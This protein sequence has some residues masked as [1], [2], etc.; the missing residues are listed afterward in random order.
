MKTKKIFSVPIN[1]KLSELEFAEFYSFC[2]HH[3]D[4][5]SDLY[6]TSRI[7]P[8]TQDAMGD[9]FVIN[10]DRTGLIENALNIQKY[11]GIP[12]SATFNNTTISPTQQNL[13]TFIKNFKPLYDAGIKIATIP[14][15]HWMAT[16]QIK[17]AFPDLFVKN[18]ILR[19]VRTAVEIVNLAKYGF[20]Y[21]NLDRDLMR[22]RDTLLR[23]KEAKM[24]I[25]KNL[26][27]KIQYSLLAN[28]GCLGACPMMVEHFEFN[29]TRIERSPQY[30]N[31]PISR[32]SCPKW[33]VEDPSVFL[34]TASLPP[35]RSDWEEF[36]D[37]LGIDVFKM[38]G[39]ESVDRLKETMTLIS[40]Y[41]K[42][43]E[44]LYPTFVDWLK[45]T[46]LEEKP[47]DIWRE[48]IKNCK[49]DCWECQYCDKITEKKSSWDYSDLVKHTAQC[50]ADSGIPKLKNEIP[51]LTSSRVRTLINSL[52]KGV[53]SYL[54]VGS[55][56]GAT[57]TAALANNMLSA[58]FV[59]KWQENIQPQRE[60]IVTPDNSKKAFLKNIEKVSGNSLVKVYDN[61]LFETP[62]H[63]FTNQIQ[64]FF[65]DGP[66]DHDSTSQAVQYYWSCFQTECILVFDDANWEGVVSGANQ[67]IE[68][69]KG[70]M[71]YKKIILN[72]E[73]NPNEWWNGL[74]VVVI[75]KEHENY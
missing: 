43:E 30:F 45:E 5:I 7:A 56:L 72:S 73:E 66:H 71:V 61:D 74:Y 11:L 41:A 49:F 38:H 50:I 8:F 31:D 26:G 16:G 2:E 47:I 59:D 53:G 21:I 42:G 20:D 46:N 39:R 62:I 48:K 13:D 44:I 27:K 4:W 29:N 32:V 65:Y 69:M 24:W 51:G 23:L 18:T 34:K 6:F 3:K 60:D 37:N 15:T 64:M 36:L 57:A 10:E 35:W 22:D 1:P 67:G 19:D 12:I 40:E 70:R 55:Y 68:S 58:Y 28:E 9:I 54:E 25:E 75:R 14:H 63:E 52:A 33:E 17:A